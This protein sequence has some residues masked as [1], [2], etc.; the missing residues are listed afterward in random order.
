MSTYLDSW[1]DGVSGAIAS[2]SSWSS[3]GEASGA[4][5]CILLFDPNKDG[6]VKSFVSCALDDGCGE[7]IVWDDVSVGWVC[8]DM[9]DRP[10]YGDMVG[11]LGEDDG[12]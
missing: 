12:G 11:C 6:S 10:G 9:T 7:A 2:L 4:K 8:G 1:S 5:G 3:S